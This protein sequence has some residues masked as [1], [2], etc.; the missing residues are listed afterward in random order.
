VGC[1]NVEA[2]GA[3]IQAG[4]DVVIHHGVSPDQMAQIMVAILGWLYVIYVALFA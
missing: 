2:E 1:N 4:R 3:A